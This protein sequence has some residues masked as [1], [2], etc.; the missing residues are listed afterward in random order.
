MTN[1]N[2]HPEIAEV[3]W[4]DDAFRVEQTRWKTWRSF[5]KEGK[6]VITSLSQDNCIA[7]TRQYLKW[8]QEGFPEATKHEGVVGGKL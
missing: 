2:E 8:Q 4:I 3:Q 7:A 6:E 5:T 1:Q